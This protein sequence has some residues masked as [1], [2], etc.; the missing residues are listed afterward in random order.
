VRILHII[1]TYLPATRYGGPIYSVHGLARAQAAL[2]HDVH[3]L[4][5]SVDGPGDSQVPHQVPVLR[6][7]VNVHYFRSRWLRRLYYAPLMRPWLRAQIHT[8]DVVHIHAVFLWPNWVAAR[9][10][11]NANVPYVVAPRGMLVPELFAAKSGFIKR[12]WLRFIERRTLRNA[13]RFHATAELE[14]NDARRLNVPVQ[15]PFV[16]GNGVDLPQPNFQADTE[17]ALFSRPYV[18]FLGRIS[19][20]KR[21]DHLISAIAQVPDLDLVLAGPDDENALP[22]LIAHAKALK[23]QARVHAVGAV[24]GAIKQNY[25]Q[26]ARVLALVS[27]NENFGNVALEAMALGRPVLLSASVGLAAEVA[28]VQAGWI[29]DETLPQLVAA[30]Q[31]IAAK[32]LLCN[33][34]GQNGKALVL[35]GYS[36][37]A[38]AERVLQAY[39]RAPAHG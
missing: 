6:D 32:P 27:T 14:I 26:H 9:A 2:G 31:E 33:Q 16:A 24:H 29:C 23:L 35:Q 22:G 30:L 36:W 39:P 1:A 5:T 34:L 21:L 11:E 19:W 4:T 28:R 12:L 15:N 13:A 25:L 37:V 17:P 7:G 38:I 8:F 3:V 20:K 18:L 10:A